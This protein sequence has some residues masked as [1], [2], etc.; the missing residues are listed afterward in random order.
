VSSKCY[1]KNQVGPLSCQQCLPASKS[2]G[3]AAVGTGC[4]IS[5]T[6]YAKG[7]K[8][9]IGCAECDPTKDKY[10]WTALTGLCKISGKCYKKAAKH[11]GACAECDPTTSGTSWTVKGTTHCL[12]KN[13]CVA[14][15]AKDPTGCT[16]CQPSVN[17]Y[18]YSPLPG[19]CK[20]SGK[21]HTKGTK[22]S[23]GCAECDP[24]ANFSKWTVKGTTHCL[25]NNV[26]IASG[27]KNP[28]TGSCTTCQPAKDKYSYYPDPGYC[29]ISGKCY[30]DGTAHPGACATCKVASSMTKWTPNSATECVLNGKCAKVCG[31]TCTDVLSSTSHCGKCNNKCAPTLVC[32]QGNCTQYVPGSKTFSYTGIVQTW[33]VPPGVKKVKVEA[34]GAQGGDS[35]KGAGGK[36]GMASGDVV[37]TAGSTVHIYVGGEGKDDQSCNAAG[38]FNGGGPTGSTCCSNSGSKA[39]T[40]G[41]AS[42]V[43]VGGSALTN[44]VIVAAG[45]GGGGSGNAGAAGGGLTG[46]KGGAYGG[47]SAGG[48]TQTAGGGAGGYYASHTCSKASAGTSGVGGKGDGNDGGGG[49]GGWYGGG[50]GAN[51]YGGGG[52][53]SYYGSSLVSNGATTKGVRTG[54]GQIKLTW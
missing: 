5:N 30:K 49:G 42:D 38:G 45:G 7:K 16:S 13:S 37:V 50:G 29:G 31:G 28:T 32:N 39:G 36:G 12:I 48:G 1:L 52:G 4:L 21:C 27:A 22:H 40:G 2:T 9:T 44:R 34:W 6:C 25:I 19:V 23:G 3:W 33:V 14:K 17:K 26:C 10:N 51:N 24:A 35:N 15:G 11:P 18:A 20:I 47:V 53:S 41:G 54:D 8:D 46:D 43:R